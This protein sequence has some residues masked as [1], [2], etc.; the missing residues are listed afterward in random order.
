MFLK[1]SFWY[2][3]SA[4]YKSVSIDNTY[5]ISNCPLYFFFFLIFLLLC[6][7]LPNNITFVLL[8]SVVFIV[9]LLNKH[10]GLKH[11]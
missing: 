4:P 2:E 1:F 8:S 10:I 9:K 3:A 11:F 6:S 7:F 5:R